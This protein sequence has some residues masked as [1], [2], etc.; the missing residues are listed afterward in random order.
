MDGNAWTRGQNG[1][2]IGRTSALE[3]NGARTKPPVRPTRTWWLIAKDGEEGTEPFAIERG[4]G[5]VL[6]VFGFEEEAE[7]FLQL[8]ALGDGWRVREIGDGELVSMLVGPRLNVTKVALDPLPVA[9]GG[10]TLIELTGMD[11]EAF[12]RT[13]VGERWPAR[14]RLDPGGPAGR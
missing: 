9:V 4:G 12:K 7:M 5:K 11:S 3:G 2:A 8:G 13:L 1:G 10:E 14:N 6:P